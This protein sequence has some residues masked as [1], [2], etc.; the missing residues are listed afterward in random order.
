MW[1]SY[2]GSARRTRSSATR[3]ILV[4]QGG[5]D[6]QVAVADDLPAWREGLPEATINVLAAGNHLFFAGAGPSTVADY[7]V[8][9]HLD[10]AVV[11]TI[12]DWLP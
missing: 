7:Q 5:R 8:P 12:S 2:G 6:Y 1:R 10:P 11:T 9:G 3:W 4:L